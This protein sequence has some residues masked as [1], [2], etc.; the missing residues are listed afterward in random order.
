MGR[1]NL[2]LGLSRKTSSGFLPVI[3]LAIDKH[4]KSWAFCS[5]ALLKTTG[6]EHPLQRTLWEVLSEQIECRG[7][8]RQTWVGVLNPPG[9]FCTL[10]ESLDISPSP[11]EAEISTQSSSAGALGALGAGMWISPGDRPH[12]HRGIGATTRGPPCPP[13]SGNSHLSICPDLLSKSWVFS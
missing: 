12:Q 6:L 2:G 3:F 11:R 7:C 1:P 10:G 13:L 9:T 5:S 8:D 4:R